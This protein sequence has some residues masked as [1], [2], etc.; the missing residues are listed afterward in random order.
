M[1]G[2]M[3]TKQCLDSCMKNFL[4]Y[5]AD[6]LLIWIHVHSILCT[7]ALVQVS[8]FMEVKPKSLHWTYM[9]FLRVQLPGRRICSQC[10]KHSMLNNMYFYV[11]YQPR[12]I[13]LTKVL[14]RI[15]QQMPVIVEMWKEFAKLDSKNQPQSAA[16]RIIVSKLQKKHSLCVQLE[17][18]VSVSTL[19]DKYLVFFQR[20]QPLIHLLSDEMQAL[21]RQLKRSFLK[22]ECIKEKL[23][24]TN[25]ESSNQLSEQ[26]M[27]IWKKTNLA[28]KKFFRG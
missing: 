22:Q 15:I 21:L 25:T 6:L 3:L 20:E 23:R 19:F 11:M 26:E 7:M 8:K 10:S 28:L 9:P 16:H 4:K 18:I 27:I 12:W 17:F 5:V 14:Q 1:M 2:Q 13:T 24:L